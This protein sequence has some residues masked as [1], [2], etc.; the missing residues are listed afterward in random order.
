MIGQ[1]K[2]IF[3]AVLPVFFTVVAQLCHAGTIEVSGDF[4]SAYLDSGEG[5]YGVTCRKEQEKYPQ[6]ECSTCLFKDN[7]GSIPV[8]DGRYLIQGAKESNQA[9]PVMVEAACLFTYSGEAELIDGRAVEFY[10]TNSYEY[11][12]GAR[13][14]VK[15]NT[16]YIPVDSETMQLKNGNAFTVIGGFIKDKEGYGGVFDNGDI[17]YPDPD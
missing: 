13:V 3:L 12:L 6:Y 11:W 17:V 4:S 8:A 9:V 1:I 5:V 2:R 14:Y 16:Q 15:N 7:K 10:N